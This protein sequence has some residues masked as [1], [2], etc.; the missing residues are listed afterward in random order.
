MSRHWWKHRQ[1]HL[2][3]RSKT[4]LLVA[5]VIILLLFP[6]HQ[7][8]PLRAEVH[9][10]FI[11]WTPLRSL[12][13]SVIKVD[14]KC[15]WVAQLERGWV[16]WLKVWQMKE[17]LTIG[18]EVLNIGGKGQG[19]FVTDMEWCGEQ[20]LISIIEGYDTFWEWDKK[21]EEGTLVPK[22]VPWRKKWLLFEPQTRKMVDLG[23]NEDL[24]DA[25][26]FA[27][28]S[29]DRVLIVKP[30]AGGAFG[31]RTIKVV[32]LPTAP[33]VKPKLIQELGFPYQ[34][35]GRFLLPESWFPDGQGFWAIGTDNRG[36]VKLFAVG[37]NGLAKKL[38]P[39]DHWLLH[40]GGDVYGKLPLIIEAVP[41]VALQEGRG[42]AALMSS[43]K[44]KHVCVGYYSPENL[45]KEQ[46]IVGW[47]E[48]YPEALKPLG[49][50]TLI[51][52]VPDGRRLILQEGQFAPYG[53][54]KRVWVWD[55]EAGT[56]APLEQI[57]W[58]TQVYGWIGTEWMIV[59][60]EGNPVQAEVEY[61]IGGKR[62]ELKATYEYGLLY[63]PN[64]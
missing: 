30:R 52:I 39:D 3:N 8:R 48:P 20:L 46:V 50:C 42:Y 4:F 16:G 31:V 11:E 59:E 47:D 34:Q 35:V 36:S 6:V 43:N 28:P 58:I 55:I 60:M 13:P 62:I 56:V 37:L 29:G 2:D 10:G 45:E 51:A 21:M 19:F 15:R 32:S 57:G 44:K 33:P 12:S 49:Q 61:D 41:S 22:R 18:E 14:L 64:R 40:F 26:L 53:E 5:E 9:V 38:T 7:F 63:V 25:K 24:L 54:K 1:W 27:H 17:N 23:V